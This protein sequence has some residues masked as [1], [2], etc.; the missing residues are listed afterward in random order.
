MAITNNSA[1]IFMPTPAVLAYMSANQVVTTATQPKLNLDSTIYN[2]NSWWDT[3][4]F[5]FL[6][7]TNGTYFW[8]VFAT[9]VYT[10]V[11]AS[12]TSGTRIFITNVGNGQ[13][14]DTHTGVAGNVVTQVC[15]SVIACNGSTDFIDVRF[16]Q[17]SGGD[18]TVT[19]TDVQYTRVAIFR[20]I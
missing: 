8:N 1:N 19:G 6:P 14:A 5:Q 4:N 17:A 7:I 12:Y 18:I 20:C 9:V 3:T 15:N 2:V 11:T 10:D 13:W 16:T